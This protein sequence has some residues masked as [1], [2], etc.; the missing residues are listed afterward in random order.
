MRL[1]RDERYRR[2]R[3]SARTTSAS[4]RPTASPSTRNSTII[5]SAKSRSM[6]RSTATP[7]CT[8]TGPPAPS[9]GPPSPTT[10]RTA[11]PCG[12]SATPVTVLNNVVTGEGPVAYI[13]QNGIQIS[14]GPTADKG[15][16]VS[17]TTRAED[18]SRAASST[19]RPRASRR[20]TTTCS[21]TRCPQRRQG[22]GPVQPLDPALVCNVRGLD[23]RPLILSGGRPRVRHREIAAIE[24]VPE[25]S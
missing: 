9:A 24:P 22:R 25:R 23:S 20:R 7:S 2:R 16:T 5:T 21:R 11:S 3:S 19:T 13:A 17:A 18:G 15:N 1:G 10:R 14:Y 4:S 8:S 12:L 6:G